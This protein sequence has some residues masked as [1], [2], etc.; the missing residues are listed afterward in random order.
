MTLP[1]TTVYACTYD[2]NHNVIGIVDANGTRIAQ[3]FDAADRL[4]SRA[5]GAEG[6][7][8]ES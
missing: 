2:A 3:S 5:P 7:A 8:V 4:T 1:D 6:P